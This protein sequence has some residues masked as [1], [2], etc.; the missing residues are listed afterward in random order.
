MKKKYLQFAVKLI[1]ILGLLWVVGQLQD[2][3]TR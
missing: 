2:P 3:F 1:I